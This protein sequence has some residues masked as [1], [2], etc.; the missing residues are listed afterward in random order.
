MFLLFFTISCGTGDK[1]KDPVMKGARADSSVKI[2]DPDFKFENIKKVYLY[3]EV[4]DD[5]S[6]GTL[7]G[8]AA[9][10]Q[11][12]GVE[13]IIDHGESMKYENDDLRIKTFKNLMSV[14][15][16]VA[17]LKPGNVKGNEET[18]ATVKADSVPKLVD[19][20]LELIYGK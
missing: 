9:K 6:N 19:K 18:I 1:K 12:K 3:N 10:L 11:E 5:D 2:I 15:F 16:H 7:I 20:V 4:E 8:I 14:Y 13:V 17:L